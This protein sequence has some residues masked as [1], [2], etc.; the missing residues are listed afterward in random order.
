MGGCSDIDISWADPVKFD[1]ENDYG[2]PIVLTGITLTWN[3]A[4]MGQLK[5]VKLGNA[6]IAAGN[7]G[8]SPVSLTLNDDA[9]KRTI[10]DDS[11]RTLSFAFQ[12]A[13]A[14]EG[15]SMSAVFDVGC[16]LS[17]SH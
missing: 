1:I 7:L 9:S 14:E 12:N 10:N 8:N 3:D 17:T 6:A 16:T 15:Y 2:G 13:P 5:Q 4:D 11:T